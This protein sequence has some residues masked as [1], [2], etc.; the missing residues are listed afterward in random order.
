MQT[1]S[2]FNPIYKRLGKW[3]IKV[4]W[5]WFIKNIWPEIKQ[6]IIKI[7]DKVAA[8]A[9]AKIDNWIRKSYQDKADAA[10]EK[11]DKAKSEAQSVGNEVEAERLY[12]VA[13]VWRQVAEEFRKDNEELRSKLEE[14]IQQAS[15]D[16]ETEID[17]LNVENL[18]EV[19]EDLSL[20]LRGSQAELKL[21]VPA[22][23]IE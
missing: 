9:Q 16:F 3:F 17:E 12:A 5:P 14:I 6:E 11:A 1:P 19:G 18:V 22:D 13:E 23:N 8:A 7:V 21:P 2:S 4:A 20:R 15:S 10:Q